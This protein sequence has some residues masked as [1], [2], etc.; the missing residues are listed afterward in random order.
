MKTGNWIAMAGIAI[1]MAGVTGVAYGQGSTT[2]VTNGPVVVTSTTPVPTVIVPTVDFTVLADKHLDYADIREAQ[3]YGYSDK[4]IAKMSII[5]RLSNQP[6]HM[7]FYAVQ[8]GETFPQL[9]D[10]YNITPDQI[11][12]TSEEQAKI[13][14]YMMAYRITGE[15]A[16]HHERMYMHIIDPYDTALES[17]VDLDTAI[18]LTSRG[19]L[20]NLRDAGNFSI[21]LRCIDT[22][23]MASSL[24]GPGPYTFFAP[25]DAAFLKLSASDLQGLMSD[26]GRLQSV[27]SFCIVPSTIDSSTLANLA[28]QNTP[29]TLQGGALQVTSSNGVM[30]VNGANVSS[31]NFAAR[32][33]VVYPIDTVLLP[34][35]ISLPLSNPLPSL[36][37]NSTNM[38]PPASTEQPAVTPNSAPNEVPN[39]TQ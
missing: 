3:L 30:Q 35:G 2:I 19:I 9:A 11:F 27:L 31:T 1:V 10:Q 13:A 17:D 38:P 39:S 16:I 7:V 29:I 33:G 26:K 4:E 22:A 5:A 12:D 15:G 34:A 6:L 37:L 18:P 23:D 24:E 21:L 32:N 36:S 14:N 8:R 25:T 20:A 28:G